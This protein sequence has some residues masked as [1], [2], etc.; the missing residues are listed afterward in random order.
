MRNV[1]AQ[2]D[3]ATQSRSRRCSGTRMA[4]V[5]TAVRRFRFSIVVI[6]NMPIWTEL[7]VIP[8][9]KKAKRPLLVVFI[10]LSKSPEYPVGGHLQSNADTPVGVYSSGLVE[11]L[12]TGSLSELVMVTCGSL[13]WRRISAVK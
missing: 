7:R 1:G 11:R 5:Q 10:R 8:A 4:R 3:S 13:T 12:V 6:L 2:G 9:V